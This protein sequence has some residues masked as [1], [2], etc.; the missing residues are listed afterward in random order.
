VK[1]YAAAAHQ[2]ASLTEVRPF[3]AESFAALGH[4]LVLASDFDAAE[5]PL[6]RAIGLSLRTP[7]MAEDFARIR[8]A[9]KMTRLR[10]LT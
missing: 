6:Q 7:Q 3:D 10:C 8:L 9:Q 5:A 4:T 1:D 2:R